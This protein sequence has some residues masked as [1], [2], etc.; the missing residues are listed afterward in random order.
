MSR[1]LVIGL[2]GA[3][4]SLIRPWAQEGKLPVFQRLLATS[5]WGK[6]ES[7]IPSASPPAWTSLFTGTTPAKHGIYR[8][9]KEKKGSYFITPISS[10]DRRTEPIWS[11]LNKAGKETIMINIPF[12]Y[13]PDEVKGIMVSGLGTPSKSSNFT[14]PAVFKKKI[15]SCVPDYDVDF[16]EDLLLQAK[17]RTS[18]LREIE[19]VTEAGNNLAKNLIENEKWHFFAYVI[20]SLDP[21]Q[22]YFWDKKEI[23]FKFY[24]Q[25]DRFLGWVVDRLE[26]KDILVL[27][28]DH[29][30]CR[31]H[32]RTYINNWLE[33]QGLFVMGKG[34][35]SLPVA[36]EKFLSWLTKHGLKGFVWRAK[37]SRL[38]EPLLRLF[39]PRSLKSLIKTDWQNTRAYFLEGSDGMIN[40][41]LRDRQAS[42]I[43]KRE[44]YERY[45]DQIIEK[46]KELRDPRTGAKV[47]LDAKK[48]EEIYG[49]RA[50]DMPDIILL[51]NED[52]ILK[53]YNYKG[54]IFEKIKE[55]TGEHAREGIL[56]FHG[57]G[58]KQEAEIVGA[59]VYDLFPTFLDIL[60]LPLPAG[61]DGKVLKEVFK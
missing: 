61:L 54:E 49:Y 36:P 56:L 46:I 11:L 40:I 50:A 17:D 31:V 58:I 7:T 4:W 37:R 19:K 32:S 55:R 35:K 33:E 24:Q 25:V 13:P 52:Y 39:S 16:R 29:G 42:G 60:G 5:T 10:R 21:L 51:K 57:P 18:F 53:G 2:D 8:F 28:S 44:D 23:L 20:R 30:F 47:I 27:C 48:A 6:L 1:I 41:N 34:S 22:H 12:T 43:V 14:Y 59:Q 45:R 9:V 38:L 15:F 26:K 3:T